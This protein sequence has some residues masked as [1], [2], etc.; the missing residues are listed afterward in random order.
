M[1]IGFISGRRVFYA[2]SA[3]MILGSILLT[4]LWGLRFGIDFTGGSLVEVRFEQRPEIR[5]VR[6]AIEEKGFQATVQSS[7]EQGALLRLGALEESKHQELLAGLREKFGTVTEERF[8]SIG[9]VIGSEL[10]R[11]ATIGVILTLLLIGLY[12]WWAFRK[13]TGPV[14][15]WKYGALTILTA[16]HDVIVPIGAFAIFGHFWGWEVGTAFVA[17]MLTILGYSINDTVVVFDRVREN[18]H[19]VGHLPFPELV[20]R[21]IRETIMRSLSTSFTT[22]LA[23]SAIAI[24]GGETTRPFAIALIIG[25]AVGTYSSIFIAS[26]LLV[27]WQRKG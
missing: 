3:V 8:D 10:R 18:S 9:P 24:F 1:S 5:L 16:F 14:S 12:I 19:R 6:Q 26:P 21:S 27:D 25:I 20:E 7:G 4:A 2:I 13:V 23:L 22:L 15:G 11:T 17:A